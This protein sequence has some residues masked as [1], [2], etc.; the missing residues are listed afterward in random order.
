MEVNPNRSLS[1]A[2]DKSD[3]FSLP[4]SILYNKIKDLTRLYFQDQMSDLQVQ[5]LDKRIFTVIS[6]KENVKELEADE[7]LL[8]ITISKVCNELLVSSKSIWEPE[9]HLT[10]D[11]QYQIYNILRGNFSSLEEIR[12]DTT[13]ISSVFWATNPELIEDARTLIQQ[14]LAD[15]F[16]QFSNPSLFESDEF[17]LEMIMGDLLA[18]YPF[19]MPRDGEMIRLP[20]KI[21]EVWCLEDYITD[22]IELTHEV[23]GSP[24][25]AYGLRPA[26]DL[27]S[28][29]LLFKGTTY[30]T[31]EGALLSLMT[32]VNP[33][34]AVGSYG[35]WLGKDRIQ[36]WIDKQTAKVI[37]YGKSLGGAL[38]WRTA[39]NFPG[40]IEKVMA[41]G[42]PGFSPL[43]LN[44]FYQVHE[45]YP[46]L[47]FNFFCQRNDLVPFSDCVAKTGVNYYEV[48]SAECQNNALAAHADMYST[49]E[50]S[51]ILK[52][53]PEYIQSPLKRAAVTVARL[54]TT[55]LFPIGC[56]GV[57]ANAT[58]NT[59]FKK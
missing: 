32:D 44:Q 42:A 8:F 10:T 30:P 41:Y 5:I 28:P 20:V 12:Q 47:Q 3:F 39:L 25:V 50:C 26:N 35:F 40:K 36:S 43:E 31:D 17:H 52:L 34:G 15:L 27:A 58:Y 38:A 48:L 45:N 55:L 54:T 56:A 53:Q 11:R 19:L 23:L 22:R 13:F 37:V 2:S 7:Q 1:I 33:L 24:L 59:L 9:V 49:H 29:L 14:L 46:D 18:L 4:D 6:R 57:L 21:N 51:M 16:R